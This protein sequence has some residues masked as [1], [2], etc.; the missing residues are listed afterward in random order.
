MLK[1][2]NTLTSLNLSYG[3]IFDSLKGVGE[4]LQGNKSLTYLDL[5]D[6][7]F[8]GEVLDSFFN[9]LKT[10]TTLKTLILSSTP[11]MFMHLFGKVYKHVPSL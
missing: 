11:Q 10:N 2:N 8:S 3:N 9:S 6:N 4:S 1:A 7:Y 5:S